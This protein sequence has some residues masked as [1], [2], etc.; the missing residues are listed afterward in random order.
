ML[1]LSASGYLLVGI[2]RSGALKD[3]LLLLNPRCGAASGINL[4]RVLQKL[5]LTRKEVDPLL[6]DYL[7]DVGRE[8]R[9]AVSVRADRCGV[10]TYVKQLEQ[11]P[12]GELHVTAGES[13]FEMRS[14][15]QLS[16]DEPINRET[17]VIYLPTLSDNRPVCS[18]LR[19]A[20]YTNIDNYDDNACDLQAPVKAGRKAAGDAV[21]T[22][23]ASMYA[24]LLRSM[25]DFA[26]PKRSGDP[27]SLARS[28][29][30]I[31]TAR[32]RGPAVRASTPMS[33]SCRC[34]GPRRAAMYLPGNARPATPSPGAG[35]SG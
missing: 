3:D 1:D 21:C 26:R 29:C 35:A 14:L 13:P 2:D 31:P 27:W 34:T 8:Q 20:G 28:A 18:M 24:D 6:A 32:V 4:D 19:G 33:T 9:D 23:L 15:D 10:F 12:H 11:G 5:A 17:D 22:P 16:V 7:G 25:D 30:F